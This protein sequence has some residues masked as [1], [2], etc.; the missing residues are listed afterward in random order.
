ML[1]KKLVWFGA[2][3]VINT[4]VDW[5]TFWFLGMLLPNTPVAV[6]SAKAASY[7][8]GVISS[9]L[10]NTRFT[11]RQQVLA[12]GSAGMSLHG[13]LFFRFV[14]VSLV[15]L[16]LNST[17]YALLAEDQYMAFTPLII[18]T[19]ITYVV[20]FTLNHVWTFRTTG[21]R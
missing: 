5:T 21:L 19:A 10:L 4:A 13:K 14:L 18:A 8:V 6:W 11:F 17:T 3:G 9:Y 15:C 12:I 16:I 1:H 2:I 7:G 20:G